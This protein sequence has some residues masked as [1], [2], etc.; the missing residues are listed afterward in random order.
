MPIEKNVHYTMLSKI[1]PS[2]LEGIDYV[3]VVLDELKPTETSLCLLKYN[4]GMFERFETYNSLTE[5]ATTAT[6]ELL[7]LY[8][9]REVIASDREY[10]T[11][12]DPRLHA[13]LSKLS[14]SNIQLVSEKIPEF[15]EQFKNQKVTMLSLHKNK[16]KSF[17]KSIV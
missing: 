17:K 4:N 3:N 10:F 14:Y 16:N 7:M 8:V 2:D 5:F 12:D 6:K 1:T 15:A 9:K 13:F 11:K